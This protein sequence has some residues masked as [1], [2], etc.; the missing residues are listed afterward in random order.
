MLCS[1]WFCKSYILKI[2]TAASAVLYF[3]KT[4]CELC[5]PVVTK[6][7]KSKPSSFIRRTIVIFIL[8]WTS[9]LPIF[10]SSFHSFQASRYIF[11][12][13]CN[14]DCIISFSFS[15]SL[16]TSVIFFND[17]YTAVSGGIKRNSLSPFS[18]DLQGKRCHARFHCERCNESELL[19]WL[20]NFPEDD[21]KEIIAVM[22]YEALRWKQP[23]VI[24]RLRSS[25]VLVIR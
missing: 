21:T 4:F 12:A 8:C 20:Q 13:P 3:L 6:A 9:A 24:L 25:D 7:A 19:G 17:V 18:H 15:S 2:R 16:S 5:L 22:Y 10:F 23:V 11:W 1:S 14:L